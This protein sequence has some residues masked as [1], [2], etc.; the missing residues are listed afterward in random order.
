MVGALV[1]S[2]DVIKRQA[3][4]MESMMRNREL[5]ETMMMQVTLREELASAKRRAEE[6]RAGHNATKMAAM[7][8]EVELEHRAI[9]S[10]I[11]LAWIQ[12]TVADER[13]AKATKLEQKVALLEVQCACLNQELQDI[14]ARVH[15]EQKKALEEANQAWQEELECARQGQREAEN[16]LSSLEARLIYSFF[17]L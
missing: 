16:K 15:G 9:E 13:T 12:L 14:E 17:F 2:M 3:A 7:E 1:N 8:R 10:S 6:E 11:A 5:S 4:F